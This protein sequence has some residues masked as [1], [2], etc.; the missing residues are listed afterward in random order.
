MGG[1]SPVA[2]AETLYCAN[3]PTVE[4]LLRCNK[5]GKPICTRC[6]IRTPVGVRCRECAQLRRPPMYAVGP[7][8]YLLAAA[9]ALPVSFLAGL[10]MQQIGWFFAF[11]IGGAV[12]GLIGEVV[13]RAT[14]KRGT[15]LAWVVSGCILIGALASAAS[16][17]AF[18]P[19]VSLAALLNPQVLLSLVMRSNVVYV[20]LAIAAAFARLR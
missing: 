16:L 20:V 4:T 19:G 8:H 18:L 15:G 1:T 13:Y 11:F 12:G 7:L 17:I 14:R 2:G 6:G 10:V 5:C 9:V 3:H